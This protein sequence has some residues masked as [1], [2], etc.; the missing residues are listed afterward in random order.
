[1]TFEYKSYTGKGYHVKVAIGK[2]VCGYLSFSKED[3]LW[4]MANCKDTIN[5]VELK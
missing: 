5:F 1:M 4:V 3:F 2:I